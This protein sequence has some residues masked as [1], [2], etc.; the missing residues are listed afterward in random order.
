MCVWAKKKKIGLE[1]EPTNKKKI[2]IQL[3]PELTF[4]ERFDCVYRTTHSAIFFFIQTLC[5]IHSQAERAPTQMT[6]TRHD[7][8][9]I[10]MDAFTVYI[11][12]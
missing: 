1:Q 11:D 3:K 5:S 2:K 12:Y 8:R 6:H 9:S 7:R 4:Y 10:D